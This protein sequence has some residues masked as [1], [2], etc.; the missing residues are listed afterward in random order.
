VPN[1]SRTARIVLVRPAINAATVAPF[2]LR[3][4]KLI[5]VDSVMAPRERRLDAWSNLASELKPHTLEKITQEITLAQS[6]DWAPKILA[7]AVKGRL[8]VNV[9]A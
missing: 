6:L 2:I 9:S 5:G 8:V 3:G 4:V 1:A 7:G